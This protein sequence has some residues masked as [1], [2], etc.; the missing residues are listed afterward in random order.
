LPIAARK[1]VGAV[2]RRRPGSGGKSEKELETAKKSGHGG[3][4]DA[5]EM[6][7]GDFPRRRESEKIPAGST[8]RVEN[9]EIF[10][11]MIFCNLLYDVLG[12]EKHSSTRFRSGVHQSGISVA[13]QL[14]FFPN[15]ESGQ[16]ALKVFPERKRKRRKV[17]I[18]E[19]IVLPEYPVADE[20]TAK[21][22]R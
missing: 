11:Y 8:A 2:D 19:G 10:A 17:K 16:V 4:I 7:Q 13:E 5:R 14:I 15:F 1:A 22:D 9:E 20:G 6:L 18:A 21:V 3:N 12:G